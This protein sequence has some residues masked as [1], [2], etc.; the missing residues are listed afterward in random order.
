VI[1]KSPRRRSS[2]LAQAGYRIKG[3]VLTKDGAPVSFEIMVKDRNQERLALN[4]S[5]SLRRIGV[6]AQVRLVDE[7]QYQRRRQKFDFD[8]M[9]GQWIA[10]A[11]PGNEQRNR[12]G[13]ASATQEASFNLAGAS[14]PAIDAMISALLAAQTHDEFIT[15]VRAYDRVLLSGFYVVPC[16]MPLNNGT[17]TRPLSFIQRKR[18]ATPRPCLDQPWKAGR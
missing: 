5:S 14:S 18:P 8:M 3:D 11:S 10:S 2:A 16:F 4:F 12:W 1:V 9:I 17:P 15:A 6:E 13:S 7:V